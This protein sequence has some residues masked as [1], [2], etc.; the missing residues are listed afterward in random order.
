[1]IVPLTLT[2]FLERAEQVYGDRVAVVDEPDPPG[3]G[4]GRITYAQ[5]A[6]MARSLAAALDDLGVGEGE[7]VAIVSPNAGALPGEPLRGERLRPHPR[8]GQLPPQRRGDPLHHRALGL[9]GGPRRS[10]DGRGR[11]AHPGEAP[12]RPRRGDGHR[13]LRSR[14]GA[15]ALRRGRR[16]RHRVG[17]LHLGDYRAPEGG[18]AH[19]P[20]LLA[21]RRHLR[22][23]RGGLRPRRVSPYPAHLPLQRLGNALCRHRHGGAP[24]R[25]SGRSTA[26]RSSGGST[27]RA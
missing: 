24:G 16:E 1:M 23:A 15:A 26:R 27:P 10:R 11:P 7:R 2:D 6:G 18:A 8:A 12:L 17:Q 5:F 3:G 20:R 4:L 19:A 13:A 9:D 21:Q 25:S 22:L 14:G